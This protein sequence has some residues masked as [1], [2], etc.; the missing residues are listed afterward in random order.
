M[1]SYKTGYI[2]C[3]G[4]VDENAKRELLIVQND[5]WLITWVCVWDQNIKSVKQ[6]IQAFLS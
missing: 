6:E 4:I 2:T 3:T 5:I 1:L